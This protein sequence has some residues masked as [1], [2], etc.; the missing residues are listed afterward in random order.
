MVSSFL[1]TR[2]DLR[3][4]HL[5]QDPESGQVRS[6]ILSLQMGQMELRKGK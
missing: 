1:E 4:A 2:R 5:I 6:T 3:K